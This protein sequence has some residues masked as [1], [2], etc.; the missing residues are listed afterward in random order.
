MLASQQPARHLLRSVASRL[1]SF[2]FRIRGVPLCLIRLPCV[3]VSAGSSPG[4]VHLDPPSRRSRD[5][6]RSAAPTGRKPRE[7]ASV[8][9]SSIHLAAANCKSP[10][11]SFLPD[12]EIPACVCARAVTFY[13]EPTRLLCV[14]KATIISRFLASSLYRANRNCV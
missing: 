12:T 6:R 1:A 13:I 5:G 2:C 9:R 14:A 4:L 8:C 7:K 10:F 11:L 3:R